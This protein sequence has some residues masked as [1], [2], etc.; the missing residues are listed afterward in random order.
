[1]LIVP[2]LQ[3][4]D[5]MLLVVQVEADD[6]F[7]HSRCEHENKTVADSF[8]LPFIDCRFARL[9]LHKEVH[10]AIVKVI[11]G[12]DNLELASAQR[13]DQQRFRSAKARD[14][15]A[16]VFPHACV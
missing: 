15:T 5:P 12:S 16:H 7:I 14:D 2:A 1:M 4:G 3:L 13:L 10:L 6:A 11:T 8:P 9:R